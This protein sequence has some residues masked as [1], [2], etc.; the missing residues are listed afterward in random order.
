MNNIGRISQ[1]LDQRGSLTLVAGTELTKETFPLV[2]A[3]EDAWENLSQELRHDQELQFHRSRGGQD[4]E[5]VL[6]TQN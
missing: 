3:R 6:V 1:S 2:L 5:M 4:S